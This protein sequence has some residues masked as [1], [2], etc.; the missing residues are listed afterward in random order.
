MSS[1]G[2]VL[3]PRRG[4][5]SVSVG[6]EFSGDIVDQKLG[7]DETDVGTSHRHL[8][9]KLRVKSCWRCATFFG[10]FVVP[11]RNV[12]LKPLAGLGYLQA[13]VIYYVL[14]LEG[15]SKSW[16]MDNLVTLYVRF[17]LSLLFF[18]LGIVILINAVWRGLPCTHPRRS[19]VVSSAEVVQDSS[20][21]ADPGDDF[22]DAVVST[23]PGT[24]GARTIPKFAESTTQLSSTLLRISSAM[25]HYLVRIRQFRAQLLSRRPW[26]E[27]LGLLCFVAI[28]FLIVFCVQDQGSSY[29]AHGRLNMLVFLVLSACIVI[30]ILPVVLQP[31]WRRRCFVLGF[32]VVTVWVYLATVLP[33]W[34]KLWPRSHG[35]DDFVRWFG[36]EFYEFYFHENVH[37]TMT[38]STRR[39]VRSLSSF[40]VLFSIR[41]LVAQKENNT[42]RQHRY[43]LNRYWSGGG[44][45]AKCARPLRGWLR[46]RFA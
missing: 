3:A 10:R 38:S 34:V 45:V 17:L 36:A 26:V 5:D 25:F 46:F 15:G 2:V 12:V 41:P 22:C 44:P 39:Q 40:I 28:E 24:T 32:Y 19:R 29:V 14:A 20:T 33:P 16:V 6:Q 11:V 43:V 9:R 1:G 37:T 35:S 4:H 18:V 27:P 13:A 8:T 31:N 7:A 42:Q 21:Q 23:A 30:L